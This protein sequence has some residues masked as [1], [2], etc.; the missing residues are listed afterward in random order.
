MDE[1]EVVPLKNDQHI[2]PVYERSSPDVTFAETNSTANLV[3]YV[4]IDDS[5]QYEVVTLSGETIQNF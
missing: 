1:Y 3:R 4:A 2:M 5:S